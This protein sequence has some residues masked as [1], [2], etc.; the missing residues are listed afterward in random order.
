MAKR[1]TRDMA[2]ARRGEE[3]EGLFYKVLRHFDIVSGF[4]R[5]NKNK[6]KFEKFYSG[7]IYRGILEIMDPFELFQ[8]GVKLP[9]KR[10]QFND[11]R[12][13]AIENIMAP[14]NQ[15]KIV[16]LLVEPIYQKTPAAAYSEFKKKFLKKQGLQDPL[17][18]IPHAR[19]KFQSPRK[20]VQE[21][22]A[23]K[24]PKGDLRYEDIVR[25]LEQYLF[26]ER[27]HNYPHQGAEKFEKL[28]SFLR[29]HKLSPRKEIQELI[30]QVG[31][32]QKRRL[33]LVPAKPRSRH[34]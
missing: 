2:I 16:K 14:G 1:I 34:R 32:P 24:I 8:S 23:E 15:E 20:E 27:I 11:L 31:I 18:N 30:R 3:A 28:L 29:A 25:A 4:E 9:E 26:T 12:K 5:A 21:A 13:K 33:I 17:E 6:F 22:K 7:K 19:K 10:K